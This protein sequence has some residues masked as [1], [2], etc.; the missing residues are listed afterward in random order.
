MI[1]METIG[2]I[3]VAKINPVLKSDKDVANY[4]FMKD[5]EV[6][7]LI[8]NT[9]TGDDSYKNKYTFKAG[10]FLNGYNVAAWKDQVLVIDDEHIAYA[11]GKGY[12]DLAAGNFLT[13]NDEGKLAVADAA[14]ESGVYF[15]VTKKTMLVGNAVK[16]R[17]AI[18]G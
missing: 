15:V 1:K 9:L 18:A 8:C 14:P 12:A 6:V 11:E 2:M 13:I 5:G 17:V 10:E 7:Y 3:D 16:A 4:S